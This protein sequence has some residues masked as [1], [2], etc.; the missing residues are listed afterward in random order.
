MTGS[1]GT[2]NS[3]E[4]ITYLATF[5]NGYITSEKKYVEVDNKMMLVSD[6]NYKDGAK[7]NG[8]EVT[9]FSENDFVI[10]TEYSEFKDG[11]SVE[12]KKWILEESK[13]G[14]EDIYE[15]YFK[16]NPH[17]WMTHEGAVTESNKI[18]IP[19]KIHYSHT[20]SDSDFTKLKHW[21]D[22]N[23][24]KYNLSKFFYFDK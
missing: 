17:A 6:M 22:E 9:L 12:A 2:K 1:C 8:W 24:K 18:N 15:V 23:S 20:R 7:F 21:F 14:F 11:K 19:F 3:S 13:I 4:S 16:I 10:T 5:K